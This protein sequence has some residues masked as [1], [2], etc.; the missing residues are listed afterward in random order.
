MKSFVIALRIF[1]FLT[2]LTGVA[3]PLLVTGIAQLFFPSKANG[4]IIYNGNKPVGSSLIG[5]SFDSSA[6]YFH[7]RPSAI[8]YNPLPSGG[9]NYGLTSRKLKEQFEQRKQLFTSDN[10]LDAHTEIPSE[11][12]FASASGLDPHISPEAALM[13]VDR[14]S[15]A[16]HFSDSGKIILKNLIHQLTEP[17]QF[18]CLGQERINVLLLNLE[19][20]KLK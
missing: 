3:Y 13:Q 4:S 8:S 20:D 5:Q 10:L 18:L 6:I 7:S 2:V 15:G 12:L 14:V 17:P 9:S 11:M 1:L 19:T 16:R